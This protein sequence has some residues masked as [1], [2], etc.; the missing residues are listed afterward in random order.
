M[1]HAIVIVEYERGAALSTRTAN[2]LDT[3]TS[4]EGISCLSRGVWSID[5]SKA[6]RFFAEI[7]CAVQ[8][9]AKCHVVF[10]DKKPEIISLVDT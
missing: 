5:T 7:V 9:P 3:K 4:E 8:S 1:T 6:L 2:M 10:L